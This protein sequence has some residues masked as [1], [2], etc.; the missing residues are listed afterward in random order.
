MEC[1]TTKTKHKKTNCIRNEKKDRKSER[2]MILLIIK[3]TSHPKK[4]YLH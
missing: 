1:K 4:I 2:K 3:L